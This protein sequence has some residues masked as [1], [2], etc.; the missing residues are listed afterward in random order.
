[1]SFSSSLWAKNSEI[2]LA[3]HRE[4]LKTATHFHRAVSLR[5]RFRSSYCDSKTGGAQEVFVIRFLVY[6]P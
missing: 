4:H 5:L 1:M 3:V 2:R 6:N